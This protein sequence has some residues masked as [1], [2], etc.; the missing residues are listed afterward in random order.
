MPVGF[1]TA[2]TSVTCPAGSEVLSGGYEADGVVEPVENYPS[3]SNRW[4][5]RLRNPANTPVGVIFWA[6]C[7]D[8]AG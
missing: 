1:Q 4:T 5:V 2:T 8:L 7:A 3:A 6:V